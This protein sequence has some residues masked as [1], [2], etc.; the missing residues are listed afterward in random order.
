M[1]RKNLST[2]DVSIL[3]LAANGKAD[4]QIAAELGLSLSTVR[5]YWSR[6]REKLGAATRAQAV[7][8]Y[9]RGQALSSSVLAGGHRS[10]PD[11]DVASMPMWRAG[12]DGRPLWANA[13]GTVWLRKFESDE[14]RDF[15]AECRQ[16]LSEAVQGAIKHRTP[17]IVCVPFRDHTHTAH[18]V[19]M[20]HPT[21]TTEAVVILISPR[22]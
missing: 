20:P 18:F 1:A 9:V 10:A 17:A 8:L 2:R 15:T 4:K 6:I 11:A 7:G 3:N 13:H 21:Q 12:L 16:A 5:T 19:I 22:D 14:W